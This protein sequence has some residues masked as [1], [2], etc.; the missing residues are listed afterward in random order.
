LL[1]YDFYPT[2]RRRRRKRYEML[3]ITYPKKGDVLSCILP[4]SYSALMKDD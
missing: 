4:F 2:F 1:D 3:D